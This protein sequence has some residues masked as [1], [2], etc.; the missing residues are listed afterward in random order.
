MELT[1]LRPMYPH[2]WRGIVQGLPVMMMEPLLAGIALLKMPT[3]L[4]LLHQ[5][6]TDFLRGG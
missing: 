2:G 6:V 3:W 1:G 5:P 4:R